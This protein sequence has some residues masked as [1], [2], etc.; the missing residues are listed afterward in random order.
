MAK[1]VLDASAVLALLNNEPG[2]DTVADAL[3]EG[4]MIS[5]VNVA[6]V[7]GK[8]MERGKSLD[9]ARTLLRLIAI[10]AVDFTLSLAEQTGAMR[11]VTRQRGLSLGD[12]ACLTLAQHRGI[13]ALTCDRN[14]LAAV[15]G[16]NIRIIR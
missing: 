14:W 15:P 8:L 11:L 13:P 2:A 1:A 5:T 3:K 16:I 6:E 4:A 12:R 9:E 7:I 10:E